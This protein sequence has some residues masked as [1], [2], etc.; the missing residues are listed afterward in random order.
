MSSIIWPSHL[1]TRHNLRRGKIDHLLGSALLHLFHAL[2]NK[3]RCER[4]PPL[5]NALMRDQ[6]LPGRIAPTR[7]RPD[8]G[9]N[10]G[11]ASTSAM[12]PLQCL[13]QYIGDRSRLLA[14]S[15]GDEWRYLEK[16]NTAPTTSNYPRLPARHPC[17][18]RRKPRMQAPDRRTNCR[19]VSPLHTKQL[20]SPTQRET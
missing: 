11:D 5:L 13:S 10:E 7:R 15:G 16:A 14:V 4:P 20:H 6:H 8:L 18:N 12:S 19:T 17:G 2:I 9:R 3:V 1:H